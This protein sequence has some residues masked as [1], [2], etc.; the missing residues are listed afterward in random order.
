[1]FDLVIHEIKKEEIDSLKKWGD[2]LSGRRRDEALAT[3]RNEGVQEEILATFE[4]EGKH[5]LFGLELRNQNHWNADLAKFPINRE[6][7]QI[8][9]RAIKKSKIAVPQVIYVLEAED[10]NNK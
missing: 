5:Y 8:M 6:H 7:Q 3:L 4:L 1:M 9:A 2:L 10:R